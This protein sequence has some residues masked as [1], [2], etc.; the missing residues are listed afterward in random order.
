[1]PSIECVTEDTMNTD[2]FTD[3]SPVEGCIPDDRVD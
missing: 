1:M 3:C 2:C